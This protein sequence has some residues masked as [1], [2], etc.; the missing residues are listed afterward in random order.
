MNRARG[1]L[2]YE[3]GD[4]VYDVI[5]T[6]CQDG[7]LDVVVY[8]GKHKVTMLLYTDKLDR[9]CLLNTTDAADE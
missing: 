3:G 1:E 6:V 7:T 9:I 2:E 4:M 8:A 5:W